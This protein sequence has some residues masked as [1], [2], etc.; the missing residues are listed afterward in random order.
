MKFWKNKKIFTLIIAAGISALMVLLVILNVF[1][2][3]QLKL[4]DNLYG[5]N[6]NPSEDIV[7]VGIDENTFNSETGLGPISFWS[8]ANYATTL[9]NL[10]KYE[11][12]LVL[13]DILFI[14]ERDEKGDE[15]FASALESTDK[16]ILAILSN[17]DIKNDKIFLDRTEA[18]LIPIDRFSNIDNVALG[19]NKI[20]KDAD[21][22]IR[23]YLIDYENDTPDSIYNKSLAL[24]AAELFTGKEISINDQYLTEDQLIINYSAGVDKTDKYKSVPFI[25]VYNNDYSLFNPEQ[26]KDKI[27]LIGGYDLAL[28]DSSF[29][30]VS[31]DY[32]M[33]N[34]E[35]HANAIQ[36]ILDQN[37][38]RNETLPEKLLVILLLSALSTF[39]FMYTKIRWSVL[40]LV[41][42]PT[43][44]TFAAPVMFDNGIIVDVIHP[45]L[46]LPVA[47]ISVYVYRYMTEFKEK[48]MLKDAFSK[49]VN[50]EIV[51]K[52]TNNPESLKLGGV[53]R[54][55]SIL[56]TDI[57]HFTSISEK[58][59]AES[60]VALLNEYFSAMEDVIKA[61]G[62]TLDKFEGDAIMA[63]FGAPLEMEDH[64]VH[65]CN[66]ALQMRQ[67]LA[68]L[69]QK[70][71]KDSPLP[72][73]EKKPIINFRCGIS[74]GDVIVGNIGASE[75]FNYTAIGDSVNLASRLEGANKKYET[76][77]MISES[78]YKEV[79]D[80]F[81]A[82][83]LDIIKVVGKD[84]PT[85][86]YELL[87]NKDDAPKD[88]LILLDSYNK[89]IELYHGRAFAEAMDLFTKILEK[90]PEDGPS[91]LYRQ[92]CE[93]LKDMPPPDDW[94]GVFEMGSK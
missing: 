27:V 78:T 1:E 92:R 79:K 10:N 26:F 49:Y 56:F 72:G 50:P 81:L 62:G 93:V 23:K 38:L 63:F 47:F 71:E 52:I 11:P 87:G 25:D 77:I 64:A 74:T 3:F 57:A 12:T 44:Y 14:T 4:S 70:W 94:D 20:F 28:G 45:Y 76:N 34:V 59:K 90:F 19:F 80:K 55:I 13:F 48:G 58:L 29:T 39:V 32:Q 88:A 42:V 68:E 6:P 33:H 37:F 89:G 2:V 8:R 67:K 15:M 35:I 51:N 40:Y 30:P 82:R 41:L 36:T 66:T 31:S 46:A 43:A 54:N 53:E 60:L 84:K 83:E 73:G 16:P 91:K 24:K 69:M 9:D 5:R 21:D 7:I 86:V 22:V 61:Q 18:N 75:R 17:V 85:K 65:S